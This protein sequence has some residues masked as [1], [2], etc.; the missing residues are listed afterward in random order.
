MMH[1]NFDQLQ[2]VGV[3]R[4]LVHVNDQRDRMFSLEIPGPN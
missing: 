2:S 3:G 1:S 4:K